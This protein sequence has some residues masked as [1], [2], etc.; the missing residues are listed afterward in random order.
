MSNSQ[1]SAN[2][3]RDFSVLSLASPKLHGSR[4]AKLKANYEKCSIDRYWGYYAHRH[5]V[6]LARPP[7]SSPSPIRAPRIRL[8]AGRVRC[9][10]TTTPCGCL[11]GSTRVPIPPGS[12]L[13]GRDRRARTP[14]VS[15]RRVNQSV[16]F[17]FSPLTS[18]STISKPVFSRLGRTFALSPTR[19]TFSALV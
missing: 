7:P 16:F 15:A 6:R 12:P 10:S 8:Q 1:C 19:T 5:R 9:V 4:Q 17:T 18:S 3:I 2:T 14:S 13:S 11:P